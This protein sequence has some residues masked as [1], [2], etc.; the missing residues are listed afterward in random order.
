MRPMKLILDF[1]ERAQDWPDDYG[2]DT[3][4][5]LYYPNGEHAATFPEVR[6]P[7]NGRKAAKRFMKYCPNCNFTDKTKSFTS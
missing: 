4:L 7:K 1:T 3:T 5:S 2:E 6:N